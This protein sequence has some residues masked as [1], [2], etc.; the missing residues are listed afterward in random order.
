MEEV[1]VRSEEEVVEVTISDAEEVGDDAVASF[2]R[3]ASVP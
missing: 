2:T 3:R 1:A